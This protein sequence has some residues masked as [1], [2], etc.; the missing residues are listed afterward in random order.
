[1]IKDAIVN[2][3]EVAPSRTFPTAAA[4]KISVISDSLRE[5]AVS[6]RNS[7]ASER[8]AGVVD[9]NVLLSFTTHRS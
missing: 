7:I 2:F 4:S 8:S 3:G 1:M 6:A 5:L 9:V